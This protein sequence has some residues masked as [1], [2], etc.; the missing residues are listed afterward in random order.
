MLHSNT[1]PALLI[2]IDEQLHDVR[3]VLAQGEEDDLRGALRV[4]IQRVEEMK[5]LIAERDKVAADEKEKQEQIIAA[6]EKRISQLETQLAERDVELGVSRSNLK[7]VTANNEMLEEAL[8]GANGV[9]WHR[10]GES[11]PTPPPP[12]TKFLNKFRFSRPSTPSTPGQSP[13][14][15]HSASTPNLLAGTSEDDEQHLKEETERLERRQKELEDLLEKEKQARTSLEAELESLSQALFEEANKMVATERRKRAEIEDE[16]REIV[17]EK[18]AL[19]NALR[20]VE[21]ENMRFRASSTDSLPL[22]G[23]ARNDSLSSVRGTKSKPTSPAP[24]VLQRSI[25]PASGSSSSR[26]PSPSVPESTETET[27]PPSALSADDPGAST[28]SLAGSFGGEGAASTRSLAGSDVGESHEQAGSSTRAMA[29]SSL[30]D[31]SAISLNTGIESGYVSSADESPNEDTPSQTARPDSKRVS[32]PWQEPEEP[33][34][35]AD[36]P[37]SPPPTGVF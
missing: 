13:T 21:G 30:G 32:A 14:L 35:W 34:P 9:G 27:R 20:I 16:L 7:M 18:D 37:G 19:K 4:V 17:Q 23:H 11:A 15:S 22:T 29:G 8:R 31:S 36:Q 12:D 5:G 6:K 10:R 24:T 33:S 3:R 26:S 25:S 2:A 1:K 28:R